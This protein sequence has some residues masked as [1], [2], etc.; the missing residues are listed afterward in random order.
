[1]NG[2]P[3]DAN[4]LSGSSDFQSNPPKNSGDNI[5]GDPYLGFLFRCYSD[6][7]YDT[8]LFRSAARP[9]T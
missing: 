2:E 4:Y 6:P 1:M 3:S 8:F 5:N 7:P 9:V